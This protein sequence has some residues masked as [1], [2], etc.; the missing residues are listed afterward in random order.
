MWCSNLFKIGRGSSCSQ[1]DVNTLPFVLSPLRQKVFVI[2][3]VIELNLVILPSAS[4][5]ALSLSG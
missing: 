5:S 3:P 1:F 4:R 2:L